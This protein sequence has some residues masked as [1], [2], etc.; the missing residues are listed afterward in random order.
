MYLLRKQR[1]IYG[2]AKK[3]L[4]IQE[5]AAIG[6]IERQLA[7]DRFFTFDIGTETA[8]SVGG[9]LEF[10]HEGFNGVVN[11]FP[12]TCLPGAMASAVLNP[13]LGSMKV[14]YM[15]SSYDG[16]IQSNREIAISTFVHQA[17]QHMQRQLQGA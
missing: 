17:H 11:V 16:T 5:D 4:D 13:L 1:N 10:A 3:N 7:G 8:M 15:E 2:A 9:A 14:P 12:F 6:E